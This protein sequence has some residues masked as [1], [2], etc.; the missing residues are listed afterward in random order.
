MEC[1]GDKLDKFTRNTLRI[2]GISFFL[3]CMTLGYFGTEKVVNHLR[4][5]RDFNNDGTKD[6]LKIVFIMEIYF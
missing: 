4:T 2:V 6:T 5:S 1:L 3:G